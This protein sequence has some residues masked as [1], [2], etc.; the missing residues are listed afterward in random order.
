LFPSSSFLFVFSS[1][2]INDCSSL[3]SFSPYKESHPPLPHPE[4]CTSQAKGS[5]T[6]SKGEG[7]VGE[8]V[9][10]FTYSGTTHTSCASPG[11]YGGVGWCAW[12]SSYQSDRWGYCTE[13]CPIP[14]ERR[15][16][17][18]LPSLPPSFLHILQICVAV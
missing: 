16:L 13:G 7:R 11:E 14:G 8:C 10:P 6:T 18:F 9:F 3:L 17:S 5:L 4:V 2:A 12:D 15:L 1:D